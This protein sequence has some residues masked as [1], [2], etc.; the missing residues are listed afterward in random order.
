MTNDSFKGKVPEIF[1]IQIDD[2]GAWTGFSVKTSAPP[3][4]TTY[5]INVY[6][7]QGQQGRCS[8]D[9]NLWVHETKNL[10]Q[11]M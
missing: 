6:G 4:G 1:D 10:K 11:I 5:E 2:Y 8:P 3:E 7:H 9:I